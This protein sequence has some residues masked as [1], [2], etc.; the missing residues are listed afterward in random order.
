MTT[1]VGL[2]IGVI[3]VMVVFR[4][5]RPPDENIDPPSNF[6]MFFHPVHG[7]GDL[8]LGGLMVVYFVSRLILELFQTLRIIF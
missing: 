3:V 6:V 5:K 4:M 7:E 1:W 2:T 8:F